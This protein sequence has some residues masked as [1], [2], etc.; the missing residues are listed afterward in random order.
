M[1]TIHYETLAEA[2]ANHDP[3]IDQ[4]IVNPDGSVTVKTG[5]NKDNS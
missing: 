3:M 1:A 4:I 5:A 2:Y